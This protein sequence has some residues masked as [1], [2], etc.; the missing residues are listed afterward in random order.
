MKFYRSVQ[1]IAENDE[2]TG[3]VVM[4]RKALKCR[5]SFLGV[6]FKFKCGFIKK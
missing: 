5:I 2:K 4:R 6:E 3:L 1:R